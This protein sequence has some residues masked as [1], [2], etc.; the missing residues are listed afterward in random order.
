MKTVKHLI[1]TRSVFTVNKTE[2]VQAAAEFMALKNIGAV[3]VMDGERL[4]GIFSER[5]VINRVV[6]RK[7]DPATTPVASVMTTELVVAEG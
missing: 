4:V 1:E 2:M 5:D 6:A 3:S 7:L